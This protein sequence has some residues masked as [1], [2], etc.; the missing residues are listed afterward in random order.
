MKKILLFLALNIMALSVMSLVEDRKSILAQQWEYNMP[1]QNEDSVLNKQLSELDELDDIPADVKF[2]QQNIKL[3]SAEEKKQIP[4]GLMTILCSKDL[5]EFKDRMRK[6]LLLQ[7]NQDGGKKEIK[8]VYDLMRNGVVRIYRPD[9][10]SEV[11][12]TKCW[13]ISPDKQELLMFVNIRVKRL[14]H[15]VNDTVRFSIIYLSQD[16]MSLSPIRSLPD[17]RSDTSMMS[18]KKYHKEP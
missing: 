3:M 16:S 14:A 7:L 4:E 12:T 11:D 5:T 6:M 17:S 8:Y 18:F 1:R 9:G 13:T 10:L 2:M 15:L